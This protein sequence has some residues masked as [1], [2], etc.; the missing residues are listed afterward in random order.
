MVNTAPKPQSCARPAIIMHKDAQ[1][2]ISA[3]ISAPQNG[4]AHDWICRTLI[5]KTRA[6]RH[7]FS[8][9]CPPKPLFFDLAASN[10][11]Q[12]NL[13]GNARFCPWWHAFKGGR[14]AAMAPPSGQT[15]A[16]SIP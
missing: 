8:L 6:G 16:L 5:R 1:A 7:L 2:C 15:R 3:G 9:A 13:V 14:L 4:K 12:K 10:D 11:I